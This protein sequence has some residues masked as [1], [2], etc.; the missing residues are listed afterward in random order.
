MRVTYLRSAVSWLMATAAI[1]WGP[2]VES[3]EFHAAQA[4][5]IA[6]VAKDEVLARDVSGWIKLLKDKDPEHRATAAWRLA[7]LGD[8][9]VA[10]IPDL[11]T[12]LSDKRPGEDRRALVNRSI[13]QIASLALVSIGPKAIPALNDAIL[14]NPEKAIR[15]GAAST[16]IEFLEKGIEDEAIPSAL[17]KATRDSDQEVRRLTVHGLGVS[18]PKA[19]LALP[20]LIEIL[21]SDPWEWVR[22]EAATSLGLID[23]SSQTVI[24][25][26][27]DALKDQSG[28]VSSAA[29]R[30]LGNLGVSAKSSVPALV[31]ALDDTR[32]RTLPLTPDFFGTRALRCDVAEA[33][34][35]IGIE[36]KAAIPP[37]RT[38]LVK[39]RNPDMRVSTAQALFRIDPK[40]EGA[41]RAIIMELEVKGEETMGPIAAIEALSALGPKARAAVPALRR[42]LSHDDSSIRIYAAGALAEIGDRSV[43]ADLERL[44]EDENSRVRH[45]AQKS[46][47]KL[48]DP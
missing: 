11:I 27:T 15:I 2:S 14:T 48:R 12:T 45:A 34:G 30:A 47:Q 21:K 24:R 10:A 17:T 38:A 1:I 33:L 26:L 36:A 44:L 40:D 16:L 13:G 19:K 20:Q 9:A 46:L 3:Q 18:G 23:P 35:Q 6:R 25:N 42:S 41:M 37:L 8:K 7:E 22:F 4:A 39:D 31:R 5:P 29:A 43:I 32:D 28:D